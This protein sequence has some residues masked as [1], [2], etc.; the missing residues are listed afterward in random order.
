VRLIIALPAVI[1]PV[2]AWCF[3]AARLRYIMPLVASVLLLTLVPSLNSLQR[4][5][6]GPKSI[7]RADPLALRCYYHPNWASE[8]RE[9]AD[10]IEQ[11]HPKIVGFFTGA[12]S[13]DYPMQRLLLDRYS[14]PLVFAAFNATLQIPGK[15]EI[16]PDVLL[17]ARSPLTRLQHASTGT[18]YAADSR[19]GRY[20]L[21]L[22]Q[23]D[24]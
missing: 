19:I 24:Q 20:T 2:F 7:F 22:K 23:R 10:R 12:S 21:F 11:V 6:W 5:L 4:P 1:A 8:Y 14:P 15:P 13:P 9:L 3:S 17:V 18:W 16:D